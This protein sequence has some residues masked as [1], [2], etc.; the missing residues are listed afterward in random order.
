MSAGPTSSAA[1][2]LRVT[3][4]RSTIGTKPKHRATLR[5]LGLRSLGASRVLPDRP[6]IRGM[7]ARVPHL[8][9]VAAAAPEDA[10]D[11]R[12]RREASG[13]ARRSARGHTSAHREEAP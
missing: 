11:Q 5:A 13:Y 2:H 9:Q 10:D 8:V 12:R 1:S 3:Q 7:L 6:E 4:V